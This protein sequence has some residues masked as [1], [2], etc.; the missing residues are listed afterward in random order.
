VN[1]QQNNG[2]FGLNLH[3]PDRVPALLSGFVYAVRTTR[4]RWSS[5]TSAANSNEMPSCFC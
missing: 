3:R 5:K 4:R 2:G 1:N